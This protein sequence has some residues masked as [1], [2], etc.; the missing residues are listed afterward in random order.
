MVVDAVGDGIVAVPRARFAQARNGLHAQ[1]QGIVHGPDG[2]RILLRLAEFKAQVGSEGV[3]GKPGQCTPDDLLVEFA[4]IVES[5]RFSG[6]VVHPVIQLSMEDGNLA[7]QPAL[8]QGAAD[9]SGSLQ[10]AV[11][12]PDDANPAAELL[13]GLARAQQGGAAGDVTAEKGALGPAK[14]FH[15]FQIEAVEDYARGNAVVHAVDEYAHGRV[16]GEYGAGDAHATD[17]E[18]DVAR[19]RGA[20]ISRRIGHVRSD[21]CQVRREQGFDLVAGKG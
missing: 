11:V 7:K 5:C 19:K 17:E 14:D 8:D 6:R 13:G 15:G 20:G 21:I 2:K 18:V 4:Q 16:V 10:V 9:G 1:Q 3:A 12:A